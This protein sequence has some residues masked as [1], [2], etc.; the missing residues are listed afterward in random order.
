MRMTSTRVLRRRAAGAAVALAGCLLITACAGSSV[1]STASGESAGRPAAPAGGTAGQSGG[2]AA[3]PGTGSAQ[4]GVIAGLAAAGQDIVYTAQITI[5][6]DNVTAD[7]QQVTAIATAAGGYVSG[8]N[9][10]GDTSRPPGG[11]G[12]ATTMTVKVP[13]AVYPKVL[14]L[15]S[16]PSLGRQLSDRQQT[17]DVTQQV[18]NVSSLVT[19]QQ[20]TINA[21]E[22]LLKRAGSVPDL[23]QVQQQISSDETTLNSLLAQQGALNGETADA[24]ITMTLQQPPAPARKVRRPPPARHSFF[25]GLAAGSRTLWHAAG[26]A[27]TVFGALLPWAV[28]AAVLAAAGY[29]LRRRLAHRRAAPPAA[30]PP[31]VTG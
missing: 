7:V 19:S 18:A 20:D 31:A 27:V 1:S 22:G 3:Q 17:S 2:G 29:A 9:A 30:P 5:R 16:A 13:V 10:P 8:E 25:S 26:W 4:P 12:P 28:V 21:L 23:L 6:T 11:T 24:T 15:L 14:R